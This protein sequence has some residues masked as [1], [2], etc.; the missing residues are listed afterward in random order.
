MEKEVRDENSIETG[1]YQNECSIDS[2]EWKTMS[3][4]YPECRGRVDYG[5]DIL[6]FVN[7]EGTK[8]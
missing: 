4:R 2:Q 5:T 1:K 6:L 8:G 7:R 3:H